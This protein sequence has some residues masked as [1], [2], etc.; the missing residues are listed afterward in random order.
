MAITGLIMMLFLFFHVLG[1]FFIFRGPEVL[2]RY[3]AFLHDEIVLLWIVRAVLIISLLLHTLAASQLMAISREARPVGYRKLVPQAATVAS[4]SMR[5]SGVLIFAFIVFHILHL[6]TGS[7]L[8]SLFNEP[9]TYGNVVR[10]FRVPWV[11]GLYF[12][13]MIFLGLHLYQGAFGWFRTL[14]FRRKSDNS[15]SRPLALVVA[16]FIWL[17]FTIIPLA[18]LTHSL[19]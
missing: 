10:G 12:L 17:G 15:L 14:G 1:N 4:L 19:R 5:L 7:I 16:V 2:N 6:S 13:A 9:D 18:V 3:R 11:S 8:P